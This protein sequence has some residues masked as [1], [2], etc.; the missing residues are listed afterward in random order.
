MLYYMI[1]IYIFTVSILYT[2]FFLV[3]RFP[4]S[5]NPKK[6][7]NVISG[8][9]CEKNPQK[10]FLPKATHDTHRLLMR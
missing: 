4:D 10:G 7:P 5:Q 2:S 9:E 1:Y 3:L 6:L 8:F